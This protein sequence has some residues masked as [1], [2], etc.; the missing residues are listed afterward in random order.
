MANKFQKS[1]YMVKN[2]EKYVGR[3]NP[4]CR[5]SWERT[6]CI[7]L[8]LHPSV[9]QWASESIRIPY[10]DPLT[11]KQKGYFPDFFM[12]Y[13]D[14]AGEKHAEIIE[15]KPKNQTGEKK[16]KSAVNNAQIIKNHA[17]WQSA[18]AYCAKNGL[19]FRLIT[20]DILF[21]GKL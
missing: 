5:S 1:L 11:N 9:L 8:D 21:K 2:K 10:R 3:R 7:F 16:T 18:L 4:I 17:K 19:Q 6:F 20:E 12:V 13:V 14:A 15:V